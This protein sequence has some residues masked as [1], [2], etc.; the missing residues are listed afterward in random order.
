MSRSADLDHLYRNLLFHLPMF[1][2]SG[3]P[4]DVSNRHHPMT[5]TGAPAWSQLSRGIWVMN[6]NKTHPD[7]LSITAANSVDMDFTSGAFSYC[8]WIYFTT[9]TALKEIIP[10]CHGASPTAGWIIDF[11]SDGTGYVYTYSQNVSTNTGVPVV[12]ASTWYLLGIS[13]SGTSIRLYVNGRD[14]VRNAASHNDLTS[15]A[16][17]TFLFGCYNTLDPTNYGLDGKM[18][19]IRIW[20]RAL[21]PWEHLQIFNQERHLFGV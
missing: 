4:R 2:G 11:T 9:M 15:A 5:M 7:Y 17:Y 19:G 12:T 14:V 3:V 1:E 10:V 21:K 18:G 13:R 16:A 8:T 20:S 6:F